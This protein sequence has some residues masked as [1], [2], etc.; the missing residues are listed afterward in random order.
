[1]NVIN[2]YLFIS[3][4]VNTTIQIRYSQMLSSL[5]LK[6]TPGRYGIKIKKFFVVMIMLNWYIKGGKNFDKIMKG[7]VHIL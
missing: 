6:V 5:L 7:W 2:L 1:M 4:S 3:K